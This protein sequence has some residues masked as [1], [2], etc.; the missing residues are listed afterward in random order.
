MLQHYSKLL[1]LISFILLCVTLYISFIVGTIPITFKD[2]LNQLTT[3]HVSNVETIIDLRLPRIIIALCVGA[4]LSVSGALLQAVL[5][6]PLAEAQLLGVSSG[7]L[8]MRMILV[9]MTPHLFFVIPLLSFIGGMIPFLLLFLLSL[10]FNFQ[11]TRMI[12][13]GVAMYAMHAMLTGLLDLFA[14]NP[15]LK[16]PQGLTMKTWNDVKIIVISASI[17]LVITLLLISKVNLLALED[18]QANNL[19]F[20]ITKYR[21]II[22]GVAVFLASASSAIVGP[23]TF[24]GLIIPHIVRKLIGSNYKKVIPLSMILGGWFVVATDLLGRTL[25]PPLEI[26]A[27]VI[28]ML[29]GG[30]VLIY[31]ICKGAINDAN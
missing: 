24:V 26:P 2:I 31:L 17:G 16:I 18:K 22:G 15:F 13:I 25:H 1:F 23:L 6:N 11:P 21:L 28:M 7:A 5:Q 27:N 20:H 4:M 29:I 14:Q 3:G 8:V 30:P 9:L 10:K 12:L 19:G